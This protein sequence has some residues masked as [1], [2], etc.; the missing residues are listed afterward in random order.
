MRLSLRL[1]APA[2]FVVGFGALVVET[3]WMR[4]FRSFM[5]ATAPAISAGLV[6]LALGQFAGALL[7]ARLSRRSKRPLR[8]FGSLLLVGVVV[9]TAVEPLLDVG[10]RSAASTLA[11]FVSALLAT[12]PASTALGAAFPLLVTSASR[13]ASDIG[14]KGTVI[15]AAD[16][17]GAALGAALTVYWL[18]AVLGVS[19]TYAVGASA[20]GVTALVALGLS[21]TLQ[22]RTPSARSAP[23]AKPARSLLAIAFASGLGTFAAQLLL[24]QAFGRVLDQSTFA[25]GAVLTTTLLCLA[26]G[27]VVVAILHTK[28]APSTLVA[29]AG[30]LAAIG[31]SLFPRVFVGAT[32]GLSYI[33]SGEGYLRRA[34]LLCAGTVGVPMVAAACVLPSTFAWSGRD[35]NGSGS[36]AG[37]LAGSLLAANTVG[38]ITGALVAPYALLPL[39]GLWPS[40][41]LLGVVYFLV[42]LGALQGRRVRVAV[43]ALVALSVWGAGAWT[44][45]PLR[46][47]EGDILIETHRSA[48]GLVAVIEREGELLI[49]TDNHYVLGGTADTVH[50]ERQGHVPL[51]LHPAPKKA[52]FIG[53]AT[54]S[55]AGVAFD[56]GVEELVTVEIM[57]GVTDA[58]AR[59]FADHNSGVYTDPRTRIVTDDA[60][61]FVRRSPQAFDVIVAD[62]FVPWRAET[63]SLYTV[64]HFRRTK[65]R[66]ADDG[67]FCQ[68]LP[69]YQLS[70]DELLSI[71]ATFDSVFDESVVFRG[72]FYGAHA[73]IALCGGAPDLKGL[74]ARAGELREAGVEDRWVTHPL[75]PWT[76][77]VGG[78]DAVADRLADAPLNT[79]DRPFVELTAASNAARHAGRQDWTVAGAAWI[80]LSRTIAGKPSTA[81]PAE[82]RASAGGYALQT[83]STLWVAKKS[84]EASRSLAVATMLVPDELLRSAP[85]D[86]TAADVWPSR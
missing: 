44:Q 22:E 61:S 80:E 84:A 32:D 24:H 83:A 38:A 30:L 26:I 18:P 11:R 19:G 60:R 82:A 17:L 12:L 86:P 2:F 46:L 8:A 77:F 76:L 41:A 13:A 21:P 75:G 28:L 79:D 40:F 64:G 58:A 3:T 25:V 62:L 14:P 72:D 49:Q 20:L 81:A 66:L 4:W 65:A 5:G 23:S 67:V 57:P 74:S 53:T 56:H 69:L 9:A 34:L 48:A 36:G 6:A 47:A 43:V 51:L 10:A 31:F 45:A 39:F 7:G 15:Y 35:A 27:T 1:A 33:V 73:I 50:Q 52:A 16:L 54:G 59:H 29:G 68:W 55:S 42:A 63:G 71:M 37:Q 78:L 85:S 70:A